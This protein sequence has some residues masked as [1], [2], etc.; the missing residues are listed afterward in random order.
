MKYIRYGNQTIDKSDVESV[1]KCL[2]SDFLTT[3]PFTLKFEK[4]F[5]SYVGSKYA[6]TCSSGTASLHLAFLAI[7]LKKKDKVILPSIN[8]IAAANMCNLIGANIFFSDVD[9]NT[10]QMTPKLLEECI[11]KNKIKKLK[12]FCTMYHGGSP[13]YA[14]EFFRLKKKYNCFLIEDSCHAL[15]GMYSVKK[16]EFVGNC[17]YSDISTFSFHPVK[18]IT[19]GEG[20]MLVT[21]KKEFFL[22]SK[23]YR[24][25][26]ISK[27]NSKQKNNWYY[28]I[29]NIGF[30]YRMS[31]IQ[32]SLGISQ[33]KRL[34]QFINKREKIAKKYH[35]L[36]A[37]LN[38]LKFKQ[39]NIFEKDIRS[40][41]HLYII[42]FDFKKIKLSKNEFI[43]KLHK[44]KIGA[45]VHYIPN[46]LQP[47]YKKSKFNL[48]GAKQYYENSISIPIY[49][50][51]KHASVKK[52]VKIISKL[53]NKKNLK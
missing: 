2:T 27:K 36:F 8:F 4:K 51:L 31:D 16:K 29:K 43:Q 33:L 11:K 53:I 25:H 6:L 50:N 12:A 28:E 1:R 18:S 45:Q 34:N 13:R 30:N 39:K 14:K 15:G 44:N 37:K 23:L 9:K 20:G 7:G 3:G 41:W 52:V 26:G 40:A 10:G 38:L 24:N 35:T 47:L 46:H 49:P 42:N 32:A 5:S 22:K 19:T 21:N 17:K 48:T